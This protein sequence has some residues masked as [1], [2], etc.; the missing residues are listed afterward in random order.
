MKLSSNPAGSN[1][2]KPEENED[3]DASEGDPSFE[4]SLRASWDGLV[5]VQR[6]TVMVVIRR[7]GQPAIEQRMRCI[8]WEGRP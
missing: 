6:Q 1:L 7:P 3:Q 8:W 4:D 5:R 2:Y